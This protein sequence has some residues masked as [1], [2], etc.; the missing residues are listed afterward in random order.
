[1]LRASLVPLVLPDLLARLA[2]LA[3]RAPPGPP[4]LP[5]LRVLP[6]QRA[7]LALRVLRAPPVPLAPRVQSYIRNMETAENIHETKRYLPFL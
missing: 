1:M 4:D 6:A 2:Q 7:R 3:L 5:G